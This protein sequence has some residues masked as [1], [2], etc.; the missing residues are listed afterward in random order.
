MAEREEVK[1]SEKTDISPIEKKPV[2]NPVSP[3]KP[4]T[5]DKKVDMPVYSDDELKE[6]FTKPD[7]QY[8][9]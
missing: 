5:S 4:K 2:E 8:W 6:L 3:G 1:T 9:F 7:G